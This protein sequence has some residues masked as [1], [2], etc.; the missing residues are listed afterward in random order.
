MVI[1]PISESAF[2]ALVRYEL[3]VINS[4][5][6]DLERRMV[7]TEERPKEILQA[8]EAIWK[9]DPEVHPVKNSSGHIGTRAYNSGHGQ[10]ENI[11]P[12]TGNGAYLGNEDPS[13]KGESDRERY[14]DRIIP[15]ISQEIEGEEN[16]NPQEAEPAQE[17]NLHRFLILHMEEP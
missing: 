7:D 9:S 16:L 8:I 12:E 4:R 17:S 13:N 5:L 11:Q 2:Q 10:K 3:R 15:G 6:A 1:K 14:G